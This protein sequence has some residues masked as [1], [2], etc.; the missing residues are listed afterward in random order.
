LAAFVVGVPAGVGFLW[1]IIAGPLHHPLAER[2]LHHPVEKVEL[3]MFC[4][5]MAA[6]GAKLLSSFREKAALWATIL[7]E[8]DGHAAPPKHAGELLNDHAAALK[9]WSGT[10]IGRR[11]LA[12]LDFVKS[13]GSANELDDHL[14]TLAD[15]DTM[16]Q[17]ASYSLVRFITWAI[18]ILGFLGTVLGIT[19]AITGV[20][21]E[22]L[23]KDMSSV[24]SGLSL[25]FDAT[26]LGLG[27]TMVLMFISF[28]VERAEQSVLERVDATVE[29]VLGHRFARA[30]AA[31]HGPI[32]EA[33][34]ASS[35][36]LYETADGLVRRQSDLWAQSLER[37]AIVGR[38]AA[39]EQHKQLVASLEQAL[40]GTLVKHTQRLADTETQMI[41][42]Q[43]KMLS[44]IAQL[45]EI[46]QSTSQ[47]HHQG[48]TE[49]SQRLAQQTA[50]LVQLQ[51]G[52]AELARL[53]EAL[54]QNLN[55]L[56]GAGAFEEAVQSL[57]AA[58]HLLTT[59]VVPG[60]PKKVA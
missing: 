6:L 43:E 60:A 20:T 36:R 38:D 32:V 35:Q 18:P 47:K 5:A 51:Q 31:D 46:L 22:K 49:V 34:E 59:R 15:N 40:N 21:P 10:W 57:T 23:E 58:I 14:R 7:P 39:K 56:A 28:L 41:T 54:A 45:A 12:V 44:T 24:T 2:Y 27:L 17:E 30:G 9:G 33:V 42:R 52:G 3:V 19:D 26:A 11:Y 1:A 25:A 53:Q 50:A 4:A 48:L 37:I 8:W 55:A 16:S 13:R 29:A